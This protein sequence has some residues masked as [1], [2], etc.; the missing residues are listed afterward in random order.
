MSEN[1][2]VPLSRRD[3]EEIFYALETKA[4]LVKDG[5]YGPEDKPGEDGEWISHMKAIMRKIDKRVSV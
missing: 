4:K 3:W 1:I 5:Y 2:T